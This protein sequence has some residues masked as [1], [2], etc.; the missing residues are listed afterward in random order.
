MFKNSRCRLFGWELYSVDQQRFENNTTLELVLQ[1]MPVCLYVRFP[2]ATW[3]ENEKLGAGIAQIKPT[4]IIWALD[5]NG[6]NKSK[7]MVSPLLLT[8]VAPLIRFKEQIS[9]LQLLIAMHGTS[10]LRGKIS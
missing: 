6:H 2:G 4:Y 10:C 7:D 1:H 5:K 8:S 9:R 3:I